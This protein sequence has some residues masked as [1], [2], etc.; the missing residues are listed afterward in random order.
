MTV[1]GDT[2]EVA[3]VIAET[4]DGQ[5]YAARD[6][7]L[8]R[9]VAIEV[10][11]TDGAIAAL[12]RA[13][14]QLQHPG[15]RAVYALG[16]HLGTPYLV[17]E[18]VV[19]ATLAAH[20][21]RRQ[22]TGFTLAETLDVAIAIADT[23]AVIHGAGLAHE[24]LGADAI[25]LAA[26]GRVVLPDPHLGTRDVDAL[27]AAHRRDLRALARIVFALV[28]GSEPIDG[29]PIAAQL[30]ARAPAMPR[31]L[32]RV[33]AELLAEI[34]ARRPLRIG[35]VRAQL[36]ALRAHANP[37][38][39]APLAVVIADDDPAARARLG[40]IVRAVAPT[41]TIRLA[42]D[43]AE[44]LALVQHEP[45]DVLFL[46]LEM[47]T[48]GGYEVC[49]YLNGT[50]QSENLTIC[51]LGHVDDARRA[52]LHG[53]GV[54]E[55]FAQGALTDDELALAIGNVFRRLAPEP[56]DP[57]ASASMSMPMLAVAL[58]PLALAPVGGELVV[59][60]RYVV[61]RSL[62]TG[63]MGQVFEARHLQLGKKFALKILKD[64]L[65][66]DADSRARFFE[67]AKLASQISHPNIVSIVDFGDDPTVGLYMV[68]E[69]IAGESLEVATAGSAISVKRACNILAQVADA[70]D[71][72][73]RRGI[74]H[75]DIK[76]DNV[77]LVE[78]AVGTRRRRI[79]RLLDFGLANRV[80]ARTSVRETTA[81][82]PTYMA[83]EL[84]LGHP[85]TIATDLY[86]LGVLGYRLLAGRLPFDGP[87]DAVMQ[88]HI[89]A[90]LPPLGEA[91]GEV[92]DPALVALI[93]RALDKDP[94]RRHPSAAAFH[95]EINAVM[96]M[97]GLNVRRR[98]TE[99][100]AA[101]GA[102]AIP[103][104]SEPD[105][106]P[107]NAALFARSTLAQAVIAPDGRIVVA[108]TAFRA[109]V[110]GD[111]LAG[112]PLL[113][114]APQLPAWLRHVRAAG[115]SAEWRAPTTDGTLVVR[116]AP[117][118]DGLHV[119]VWRDP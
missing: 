34:P 44:T 97:M 88:A 50:R 57:A 107:A 87:T 9:D 54:D 19:G 110:P 70:L 112:S 95:Y 24:R 78:E 10:R 114:R 5:T 104:P 103:A 89:E 36:R 116:A 75:G 22:A 96:D 65:A 79:A 21:E 109:L 113:R 15:L 98:R 42:A 118:G 106:E 117:C 61:E 35:L 33:L 105:P 39:D 28:A 100:I 94:A 81:G 60:E 108:N 99:P 11:W 49:V 67:E 62:A 45:P 63:G 16:D 55:T 12:A 51:V 92:V 25:V 71:T 69:M 86:A 77:M 72:V 8:G 1:L 13:L 23:L 80:T 17:R 93:E 48:L 47:P 59:G 31:A 56:E 3:R 119:L 20:L 66:A 74:V 91:R 58:P 41:A 18:D 111:A 2:Y 53:L 76:A 30:A 52:S 6:R 29:E 82:T 83:P 73:H 26:G 46:D 40:A 115:A 102:P 85:P 43:G 4:A 14:A 101:V 7:R 64:S 37:D 68:M 84:A 32:V 90:E 38:G 27:R